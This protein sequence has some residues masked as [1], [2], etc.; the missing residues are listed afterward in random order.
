MFVVKADIHIIDEGVT[1]LYKP[2][3]R[4]REAGFYDGFLCHKCGQLMSFEDAT[5][6]VARR[7]FD[8]RE[9]IGEK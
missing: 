7:L 3:E 1:E 5:R 9:V 6:E 2:T 4:E 8:I